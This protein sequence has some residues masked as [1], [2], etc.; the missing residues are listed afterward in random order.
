MSG[1]PWFLKTAG[2][3]QEISLLTKGMIDRNAPEAIRRAVVGPKHYERPKRRKH[4]KKKG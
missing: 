2:S 3:G 1:T 4:N